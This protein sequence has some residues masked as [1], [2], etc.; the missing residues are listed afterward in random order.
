MRLSAMAQRLVY[1]RYE[2]I[3]LTPSER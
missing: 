3:K 2:V 1:R